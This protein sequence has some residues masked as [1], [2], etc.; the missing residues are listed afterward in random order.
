MEVTLEKHLVC[1]G[2]QIFN[3][4]NALLHK[5]QAPKVLVKLVKGTKHLASAVYTEMS[6]LGGNHLD[7][8]VVHATRRRRT[9]YTQTETYV[10]LEPGQDEVFV[11]KEELK[12][13]LKGWLENW[14]GKSLPPDLANFQSIDDAVSHL[15]KSVCELELDEEVG[16]IQW[17]E[18]R[19]E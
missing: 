7:K 11:S 12:T 19:L 10:L 2:A 3:C 13:R 18:V 5:F 8:V 16:S 1:D 4:K 15:V 17:Y 9:A 14:P 6:K